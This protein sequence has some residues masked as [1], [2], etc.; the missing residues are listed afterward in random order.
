MQIKQPIEIAIIEDQKEYAQTLQTIINETSSLRC[1]NIYTN[2][3]TAIVDIPK[4][5]PDIVLVD[6]GLPVMSGI[7]CIHQLKTKM[8]K[9]Q[10]MVITI[11]EDD[12]KV[13][14]ALAAGASS[15]LLKGEKLSKIVENIK[16]LYD[17]GSPM[18]AQ[19]ARKLVS[20]F[21]KSTQVQKNPYEEVLTKREKEILELASRGFMH[22]QIAGELFISIETV[23]SHFNNV[24][25]K[26]HVSSKSE[27]LMKYYR[28]I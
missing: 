18:S 22:K 16:E 27:A 12:E 5:N 20:F 8:P 6:I 1:N 26:L 23:K 4:Q 21:Q 7:E 3:E 9:L 24:Y 15:Y 14:A 2:G 10:F 17:G 28:R 11:S 25:K 19:I 13:F